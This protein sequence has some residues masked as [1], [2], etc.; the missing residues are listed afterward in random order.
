M[1]TFFIKRNKNKLTPY[2][3]LLLGF[4]LPFG[5]IATDL[6]SKQVIRSEIKERKAAFSLMQRYYARLKGA[7]EQVPL[8]QVNQSLLADARSL[9]FMSQEVQ[10]MFQT[11]VAKNE[12]RSKAKDGIWDNLAAFN[13]EMNDYVARTALLLNK[14][15]NNNT[16]SFKQDVSDLGQTCKSCHK[17]YKN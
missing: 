11:D 2:I 7:I 15:E 12:F 1:N 10:K 6:K 4:T 9:L 13:H 3:L 16:T 8:T 5:V 14:L 17:Q